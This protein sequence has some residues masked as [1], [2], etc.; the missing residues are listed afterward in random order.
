MSVPHGVDEIVPAAQGDERWHGHGGERVGIHPGEGFASRG[1][2]SKHSRLPA[3]LDAAVPRENDGGEAALADGV[4][5]ETQSERSATEGGG[6]PVE[7]IEN[8]RLRRRDNHRYVALKRG[9]RFC[10]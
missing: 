10:E 4:P 5:N 6:I 7:E 1:G 3:S 8:A 9:A 2:Q